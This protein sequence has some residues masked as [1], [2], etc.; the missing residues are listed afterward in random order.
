[1]SVNVKN[2]QSIDLDARFHTLATNVVQEARKPLGR[3]SEQFS[4][5]DGAIIENIYRLLVQIEHH[6][7]VHVEY[8]H[9]TLASKSDVKDAVAK[10]RD[11][12]VETA[13]TYETSVTPTK[14]YAKSAP[15]LTDKVA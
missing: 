15:A 3:A 6:D 4:D 14:S 12:L 9:E 8:E 7:A 2:E 13:K 5:N 1:M 10:V 11:A